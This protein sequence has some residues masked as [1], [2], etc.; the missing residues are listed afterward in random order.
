MIYLHY[1]FKVIDGKSLLPL[2]P[3]YNAAA[4]ISRSAWSYAASVSSQLP[5][6]TVER[7]R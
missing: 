3:L 1:I 2:G 6:R 5:E 4:A 7:A